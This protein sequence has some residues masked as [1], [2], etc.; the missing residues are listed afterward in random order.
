L[1]VEDCFQVFIEALEIL[2]KGGRGS[3]VPT[4]TTL[5]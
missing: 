5:G 3:K 4:P 2:E 1:T